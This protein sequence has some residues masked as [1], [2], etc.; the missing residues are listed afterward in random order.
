LTFQGY[1]VELGEIEFHSRKFLNGI[2]TVVLPFFNKNNNT[3]LTIFIEG[4]KLD[5]KP[6]EDYLRSKLPP[7]MI[8][9]KFIFNQAFPLNNNGKIDK[10]EL[11]KILLEK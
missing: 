11:K 1:R 9:T 5:I 8:P 4:I 7:Y 10:N 3:E 2:N 6:I